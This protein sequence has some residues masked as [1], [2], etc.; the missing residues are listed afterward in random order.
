MVSELSYCCLAYLAS[1]LVITFSIASVKLWCK[2][3]Y[4][5]NG[6]FIFRMVYGIVWRVYS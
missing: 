1:K 4:F 2:L 3:K 6:V 5:V